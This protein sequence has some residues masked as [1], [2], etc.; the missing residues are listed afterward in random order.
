MGAINIDIHIDG[1]VSVSEVKK[2]FNNQRVEDS[3][4]NGHQDG[5][6][7]DFQTVQEVKISMLKFETY[8]EA[9][10]YCLEKSEKWE[11]VTACRYKDNKGNLNWVIAG[12]GAC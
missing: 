12:W 11:Y 3:Y 1:D 9:Y 2:A 7:G 4:R 6:S 5:Y 8:D 10:E